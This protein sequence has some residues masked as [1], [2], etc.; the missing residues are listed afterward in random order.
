MNEN[1]RSPF[2]VQICRF[3]LQGELTAARQVALQS[4]P[5]EPVPKKQRRQTSK[6]SQQAGATGGV[7]PTD[8]Q[9]AK[10]SV[11]EVKKLSVWLRD[12]FKCRYTN[13]RLVL[14]QALELLSLV[15]PDE[16]PFHNPPHGRFDLTHIIMWELWPAIDHVAPVSRSQDTASA[17][18]LENLVTT[19][20]T[21]NSR[22]S[23]SPL[24]M[25]G[26]SLM[27]PSPT[28]DWDGLVTWYV[29]FLSNDTSWFAHPTSGKRLMGWY[30][31]LIRMRVI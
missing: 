10:R 4:L 6:E 2:V 19:S 23:S 27:P 13:A 16:L 1:D 17:N 29:T 22:K 11:S 9:K 15:L 3:L 12:G 20:A 31:R 5:F 14:P 8:A 21:L 28:E 30:R 18:A 24:S 26:W 7:L 25:L